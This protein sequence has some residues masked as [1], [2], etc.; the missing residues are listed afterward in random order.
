MRGKSGLQQDSIYRGLVKEIRANLA[1]VQVGDYEGQIELKRSSWAQKLLDKNDRSTQINLSNYLKPGFVIE[2]SLDTEKNTEK[3]SEKNKEKAAEQV[4]LL[5]FKMD[6]TPELEGAF[7]LQNPLTG[8]AKVII[9]GYD[10]DRSVFNRVTQGL[11]QPGSSF[12]PFVYLAALDSLKFTPVTLVP[13]TP[14][15]LVAGNGQLWT[16]QNFDHKYLGP[17]TFRVALQRSRNVVSVW[18]IQKLGVD[19]V[20]ETARKLGITTPIGRDFSIS[21]GTAE[22]YMNELVGAYGVFAAGGWLADQIFISTVKDRDGKV[23]FEKRP[24]QKQVIS[25]ESAFIMAHVMKGVIENGTATLLRALN[26]PMAGKT[27]TTNDLMDA[28]FIGFTPEWAAGVWV[29]FD[30]KRTIGRLE[31]GGK[32]AAP[33]FLYFMEEFLK[34]EP[35]LDFV[36]PD[37]VVPVAINRSSGQ[38]VDP[39]A[40]GSFIE[41]FKSG[42]EPSYHAP[43]PVPEEIPAE[44]SD[45]PSGDDEAVQE[46]YKTSDEM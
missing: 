43:A 39:A 8:E 11:R 7:Y 45:E 4:P 20:I 6:Q 21:L 30:I 28:W 35:P 42:T 16:P 31:T 12:K 36:I 29:G 41:Y 3:N 37:G 44:E 22:I 46:D 25:E 32:A 38:V 18:M 34:N 5:W 23:I 33:I 1:V 27:G 24:S 2:V 19:R 14:I 40:S 9:G 13:D 26:R 10:Y 17:I 15:S